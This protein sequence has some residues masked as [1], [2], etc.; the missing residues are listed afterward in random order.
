MREGDGGCRTTISISISAAVALSD[1][2]GRY[3]IVISPI[4]A[5]TTNFE[6]GVMRGIMARLF[7]WALFRST[8]HV[9]SAKT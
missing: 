8:E 4:S 3:K 9:P 1:K 6:K 7:L 2:A 5:A